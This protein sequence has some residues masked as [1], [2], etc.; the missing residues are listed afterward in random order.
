LV[1]LDILLRLTSPEI[2]MLAL[3]AIFFVL[4]L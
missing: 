1:S 3:K 2:A 4:L